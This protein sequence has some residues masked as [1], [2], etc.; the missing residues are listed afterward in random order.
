MP[1]DTKTT[2]DLVNEARALL[3]NEDGGEYDTRKFI[4][5][6]GLYKIYNYQTMGRRPVGTY[7]CGSVKLQD[8]PKC[9]YRALFIFRPEAISFRDMYKMNLLT[10][11]SPDFQ[12]V[13]EIDLFKYE[14]AVYCNASKGHVSGTRQHAVI[15]GAPGW[16]NGISAQSETAKAWF[17]F[18]VD[19][20]N[21]EWVVYDGNDFFV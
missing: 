2:L 8:T 11:V 21:R 12:L 3:S 10:L 18:L 17:G 1:T 5:E 9:L 6:S 14:M 20:L 15:A 13:A 16:D 19:L 4:E 7:P